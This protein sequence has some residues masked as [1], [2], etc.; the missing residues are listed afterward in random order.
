MSNLKNLMPLKVAKIT[1][2]DE[3]PLLYLPKAAI[4]KLG[5]RKGRRVLILLDHD[6]L[7]LKPIP[8]GEQT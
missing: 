4:E 3:W 8:E 6:A 1:S 5:L 7:V 2:N